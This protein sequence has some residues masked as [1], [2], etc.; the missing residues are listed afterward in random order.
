MAPHMHQHGNGHRDEGCILC[1]RLFL[2]IRLRLL[3]MAYG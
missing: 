2:R 1:L 3:R